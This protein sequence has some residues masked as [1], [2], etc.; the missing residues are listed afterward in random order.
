MKGH[1]DIAHKGTLG[2]DNR[3]RMSFDEGSLAHLMS[4]L[5]DLYSDP[6][7]AV[8]REYSTNARDSHV[9]AGNAD[10][11]I[12]V[13]TPSYL[14]PTLIIRDF[15]IGMD[16]H[17]IE[18]TYSK[19][20]ASTKRNTNELQGMLGLG[21][22]S[23]LA[24]TSQFTVVARKAGVKTTALVTREGD[25]AG[26][27]QVVS[28]SLITEPN[29]VEVRIPIA[30]VYSV[31]A[32]I[33]QFFRYWEAGTVLVDGEAPYCLWTDPKNMHLDPDVLLVNSETHDRHGDVIVMGGVAYPIPHRLKIG[34]TPG[35]RT[36]DVVGRVPI[37]TINFVPNRERLQMNRRTEDTI[38]EL[39]EFVR[40]M[41]TIG[42]Q[43][44]IDGAPNHAAAL[45]MGLA[46]RTMAQ[47]W[48]LTYKGD[49]LPTRLPTLS[50]RGYT[51][52]ARLI[53]LRAP[54]SEFTK[55]ESHVTSTSFDRSDF[56][57]GRIVAWVNNYSFRSPTK[58]DK[59]RIRLAV[60]RELGYDLLDPAEEQRYLDDFPNDHRIFIQCGGVIDSK[61]I[62]GPVL[63]WQWIKKNVSLPSDAV[64]KKRKA[65]PWMR[66]MDFKGD[67]IGGPD[68]MGSFEVVAWVQTRAESSPERLIRYYTDVK[69]YPQYSD[70]HK[71]CVL[72][73]VPPRYMKKWRELEYDIPTYHDA[74]CDVFI[75]AKYMH[76]D[77]LVFFFTHASPAWKHNHDLRVVD[78]VKLLA[79]DKATADTF[80]DPLFAPFVEVAEALNKLGGYAEAEQW[81]REVT[82]MRD[83]VNRMKEWWGQARNFSLDITTEETASVIGLAGALNKINKRY[84]LFDDSRQLS[85]LSDYVN[86]LHAVRNTK[87]AAKP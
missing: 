25:G 37:G 52:E 34:S 23:G 28:T 15:G 13:T 56:T 60:G 65:P 82:T 77:A 26:T 85:H 11:P 53:K 5:T 24:Y 80:S 66:F 67:Y 12:E 47:Y 63:D 57:P 84:P 69:G 29:G 9:E 74:W 10:R 43:R 71:K 14:N 32:K 62:E 45:Q 44:N 31:R 6:E 41:L 59:A 78:L 46:V 38:N 76:R 18:A 17:D 48:R 51:G 7:M 50:G 79:I 55:D 83:I 3:T 21:S 16:Q 61:W 39:E 87:K 81:Y 40:H 19:Y 86:A 70:E 2:D 30:N 27:I 72:A 4:V 36:M 33:V 42:V 8:I 35:A 54:R 73:V 22:K 68:D 20:G 49:R 58:T 1:L 64:A 75:E